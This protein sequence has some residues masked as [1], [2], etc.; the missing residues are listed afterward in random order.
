MRC[1]IAVLVDNE[2]H[3]YA[4]R[5]AAEINKNINNG[6]IGVRFLTHLSLKQ[7]YHIDNLQEMENYF[8]YLSKSIVPFEI[9][10]SGTY[11]WEKIIGLVVIENN[12][13]RSL[14]NRINKEL[15]ERFTNTAAPYDG[16]EY[17]FHVT[18]AYG[19]SSSEEYRRVY[20]LVK[21]EIYYRKVV[22]NEII[23]F[24]SEEDE[25]LNFVLY[26]KNGLG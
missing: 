2:V 26:R 12:Q 24:Y 6:F 13:L 10:V 16:E 25:G 8:D 22:I 19:G 23:L 7:P 11:L 1:G 20:E 21:D 9:E 15:K 5:K 17:R 14:H 18:I 3:N 4:M